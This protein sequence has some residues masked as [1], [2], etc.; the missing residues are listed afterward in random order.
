M[1][2]PTKERI[3]E[4]LD[5]CEELDLPDGAYWMLVHEKLGLEYGDVFDLI[6]DLGIC[7]ATEQR[8]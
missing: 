3:Q 7:E 2:T 8:G 5:E 6:I 1:P 4:V